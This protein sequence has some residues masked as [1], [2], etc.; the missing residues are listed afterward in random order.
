MGVGEIAVRVGQIQQ[1]P[2]TGIN[3]DQNWIDDDDD[4]DEIVSNSDML[5][6]RHSTKD[7]QILVWCH[8]QMHH[9]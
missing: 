3:P 1:P 8:A 7:T 5:S 6:L 2:F 9:L 4:D